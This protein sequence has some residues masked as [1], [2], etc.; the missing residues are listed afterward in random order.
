M[1]KCSDCKEIKEFMDFHK[2]NAG[3]HSYCKRC[4][5]RRSRE[6]KRKYRAEYLVTNN[7][8]RAAN[9]EA[10]RANERRYY[11]ENKDV[12]NNKSKRWRDTNGV[13]Q[14]MHLAAQGRARNKNYSYELSAA[15]I[16]VIVIS[17]QNKCALTGV[18]FDFERGDFRNKPLGPSIDRID[19]RKGYTLDNVQIVTVIANKAKNEYPVE[20]FD[21]MCLARA[22]VLGS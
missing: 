19:S 22:K 21:A 10:V 5:N 14:M 6:T 2:H 17:Q 13:Y 1:K 11:A 3:Y 9:R 4:N 16:Q 7:S 15:I 12:I 8:Y 18:T 20:F